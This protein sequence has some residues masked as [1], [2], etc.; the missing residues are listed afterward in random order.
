MIVSIA[1]SS[2]SCADIERMNSNACTAPQRSGCR[3]ARSR[4][5]AAERRATRTLTEPTAVSPEPLNH[6]PLKTDPEPYT[7]STKP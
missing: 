3:A 4:L 5:Q 6:K 1:R 2:D 7:L